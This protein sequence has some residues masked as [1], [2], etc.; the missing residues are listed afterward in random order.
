MG[1]RDG[2][3]EFRWFCYPSCRAGTRIGVDIE[4]V[5]KDINILHGARS[6]RDQTNLH[7]ISSSITRSR[8]FVVLFTETIHQSP[9]HSP[10]TIRDED[11]S[12]SKMQFTTLSFSAIA[13]FVGAV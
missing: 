7:Y 6:N 8:L 13:L 11:I 5:L 2:V 4:L 9:L 10:H 1:L 12:F 3:K